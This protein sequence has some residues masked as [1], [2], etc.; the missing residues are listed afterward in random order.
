MSYSDLKKFRNNRKQLMLKGFGNKCQICGY[1]KCDS[2]LE[3]HHLD[4][5]QK[6]F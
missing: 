1:N 6:E 4:P 5:S 2:A 3:F